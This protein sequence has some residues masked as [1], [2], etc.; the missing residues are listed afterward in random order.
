MLSQPVECILGRPPV[1]GARYTVWY[2]T[3]CV[4]VRACT[5]IPISF[6]TPGALCTRSL[7]LHF[8]AVPC[9][10]PT[11]PRP[12]SPCPP[13]L[14]ACL[15][16]TYPTQL[17]CLSTLLDCLPACLPYFFL[18]TPPP[19]MPIP[20][21]IHP[22]N[23]RWTLRRR[24]LSLSHLHTYIHTFVHT[25]MHMCTPPGTAVA[26]IP[27]RHCIALHSTALRPLFLLVLVPVPVPVPISAPAPAPVTT[28]HSIVYT[29]RPLFCWYLV[30]FAHYISILTHDSA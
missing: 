12:T 26:P 11:S 30:L 16:P 28:R 27:R 4:R 19:P 29:L 25:Y 23:T 5:C 22:K 24:S 15:P 8:P 17:A 18:P 1:D 2:G 14:P 6:P 13:C 20:F 9:R 3:G 7:S 10:S 21:P